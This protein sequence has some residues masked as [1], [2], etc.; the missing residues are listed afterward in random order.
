MRSS[1]SLIVTHVAFAVLG[2]LATSC[3][4][5]TDETDPSAALERWENYHPHSYSFTWSESCFCLEDVTRPIRIEVATG[6]DSEL[7]VGAT[8]LDDNT[9]VVDPVR[10]RLLTING[11][12]DKIQAARD[13][14]ADKVT[15]E[16]DAVLG[17]PSSVLIDYDFGIG[18]DESSL[19]ISDVSSNND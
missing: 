2:T 9:E 16:Y 5:S 7:I 12:F 8:Y 14:G 10:S 13:A 3:T 15:V 4:A 6:I 17:Y 18:D 1:I 19:T 11:V